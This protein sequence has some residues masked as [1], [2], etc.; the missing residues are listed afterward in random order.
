MHEAIG[1]KPS[2]NPVSLYSSGPSSVVVSPSQTEDDKEEEDTAS[3]SAVGSVNSEVSS[4]E[5]SASPPPKRKRKSDKSAVE[6]LREWCDNLETRQ[7]EIDDRD[8]A[9]LD[10][11]QGQMDKML[12]LFGRLVD[13]L[14]K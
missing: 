9:W 14:T 11:S 13:H 10:H 7:K 4:P 12:D 8:R 2:V 6:G 5:S 1:Q 3:V